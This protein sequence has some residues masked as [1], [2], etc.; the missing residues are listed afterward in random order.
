MSETVPTI[1]RALASSVAAASKAGEIIKNVLTKGDLGIVEKGVND[2][3]TEAD[4]SAQKCIV[5]TLRSKFP[6]MTI[7]G[8]EDIP[9]TA[10]VPSEW[11]VKDEPGF[12]TSLSCP[13]SLYEITDKDIVAWVDPLDGTRE[14]TEGFLDHVTVLI[15]LAVKGKPLCGVIH[16]PYYTEDGVVKGRTLWA[17]IGV[18]YGGFQLKPAPKDKLIVTVTRSHSD[19]LLEDAL[20]RLNPDGIVRVGGAGH[21]ALMLIEGI[22]HAYIVPSKGLKRWDTCAVE[23]ILESVGGKITDIHGNRYVYSK[24]TNASNDT[25]IIAAIDEISHEKCQSVFQE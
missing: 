4:R 1:L 14:F 12:I 3:Q 7:I 5:Q 21:K 10:S 18:G 15:G 6:G 20:V 22:A 25:G 8:E 19:K 11:I 17:I 13:S 9:L 24:D 23:A 2:P 16:Q